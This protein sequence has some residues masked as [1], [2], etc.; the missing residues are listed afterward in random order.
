[1]RKRKKEELGTTVNVTSGEDF[2]W[3]VTLVKEN[4]VVVIIGMILLVGGGSFAGGIGIWY[5]SQDDARDARI[6]HYRVSS[7]LPEL[8]QQTEQ[9]TEK[10]KRLSEQMAG[11]GKDVENLYM[12]VEDWRVSEASDIREL[13]HGQEELKRLLL[14]VLFEKQNMT[15]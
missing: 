3:L 14:K 8:K 9:N 10:I 6:D 4:P 1:M 5:W 11:V 13:R 7:E 2:G 15:D 12:K